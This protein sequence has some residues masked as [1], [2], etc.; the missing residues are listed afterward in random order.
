MYGN[1]RSTILLV[2]DV[3]GDGKKELITAALGP[4]VYFV[5]PTIAIRPTQ[6]TFGKQL[7]GTTGAAQ[8]VTIYN[9][10]VTAI[11]GLTG[12]T[13]TPFTESSTCS[14]RLARRQLPV[15]RSASLHLR[16]ADSKVRC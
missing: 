7:A 11:S 15:Q 5:T 14:A 6:L 8:Q 12:S 4:S 1:E 3:V 2:E 10:G 13:S 16:R 9:P